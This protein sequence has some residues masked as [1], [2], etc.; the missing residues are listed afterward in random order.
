MLLKTGNF[1]ASIPHKIAKRCGRLPSAFRTIARKLCKPFITIKD[2]AVH[3]DWKTRLSFAV[4]GFSHLTRHQKIRGILYLGFEIC[5]FF[6]FFSFGLNMLINLPNLGQLAVVTHYQ[7]LQPPLPP[8]KAP[9]YYDYSFNI[10][11]YAIVALIFMLIFVFLWYSQIKDSYNMQKMNYV[12]LSLSDKTTLKN[13]LD[14][15]Y[16]KTLLSIPMV[17]LVVFT[18]LPML[19]TVLIG[20]TNYDSDHLSPTALIDWVGLTNFGAVFGMSATSN[21]SLFLKVFT[22]VLIWTLIWAFFATFSNYFLG[23][24]VAILINSKTV[25]LKK[26][27]RTILITTIAVPQ[28]VSLLLINRMFNTDM[29]FVNALLSRIGVAPVKWL[30]SSTVFTKVFI[31]VINTWIGIP[32]T[33][34][35]CSGILMN[36]PDDLYESARID[37]AGPMKTFGRITLPYMLFVTGPYL[38]SQFVGNIN[39][40][41]VIYLL[42]GGGPLYTF[43]TTVPPTQ[44]VGIGRTDLLI[45]WIYKLTFTNTSKYFST[46]SVIGILIFVVVAFFSLIFYGRSNAVKNEEDFQ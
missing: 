14:K 45:T 39:N 38:I 13:V 5:F 4:M 1:F 28:F 23:M 19:I 26:I 22:E 2:A 15:S 43:G 20:F 16:H 21:S 10:L 42:S 30:D 35:I 9:V 7:D 12:G 32:Y 18:V 17:G 46:A 29:G 6:Y 36:I 34:L 33:M 24:G 11:L 8:I 25:K 40:F 3:G 37:G 41:N 31:I 27:W 44:L